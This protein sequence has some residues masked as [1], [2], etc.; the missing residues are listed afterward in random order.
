MIFYNFPESNADS[1]LDRK[2]DDTVEVSV[3]CGSVQVND[4][5]KE[6]IRNGKNRSTR[7]QPLI[8]VFE[9]EHAKWNLLKSSPVHTDTIQMTPDYILMQRQ[10]N[11]KMKEEVVKRRVI[12][13][14]FT[15]NL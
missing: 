9:S 4:L 3:L 15:F 5:P 1:S 6:T 2:S 11:T 7:P 10:L 12:D 13:Q 14:T 8:V